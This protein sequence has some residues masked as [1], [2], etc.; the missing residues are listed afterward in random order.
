MTKVN[1]ERREIALGKIIYM[2]KKKDKVGQSLREQLLKHPSPKIKRMSRDSVRRYQ[3]K[4][5]EKM[6][7][8]GDPW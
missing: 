4:K 2:E 6:G 1:S 5:K 3:E 8:K 7:N